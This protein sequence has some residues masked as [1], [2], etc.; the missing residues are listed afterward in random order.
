M[1]KELDDFF[2]YMPTHDYVYRPTRD[3]WPAASVNGSFLDDLPVFDRTGQPVLDASGKQVTIK[4][5]TWLDRHRAVHC[6]TWAP[7]LPEVIKD[8]IV[9]NGGWIDEPGADTFNL[10]RAP[11]IPKGDASQ[12]GPWIVHGKKLLGEHW[13]HVVSWLAHRVQRPFEKINHAIVLGGS[14]GI[15]KDCLLHP[16]VQAVG[17]WNVAEASPTRLLG[18]FN[19][20]YLQ[21]VILRVSEARDLGEINRFAFY[22][23]T[24]TLTAAPP[25]VLV[26]NEKF[27]P[28]RTIFNVVGV[29][30]TSNHRHSALFLPADDRRHYVVWCNVT[31]A[32]FEAGYFDKLF[33]WYRD[34]GD[35]H[36][37]AYLQAFDLGAFKAKEPPPK[38]D[39]FYAMVQ[40]NDSPEDLE[41]ADAIEALGNPGALTIGEV[42]SVPGIGTDLAELL[43]DRKARRTVPHSLERLGYTRCNNPDAKAGSQQHRWKIGEKNAY[44]YAKQ[45]LSPVDRVKAARACKARIEADIA[46]AEG[47]RPRV[48]S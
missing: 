39:A 19:A 33:A 32:D 31:S 37:A 46:K 23:A 43:S 29:F 25:D 7:G 1:T 27:T 48:V 18:Q 3:H 34:G 35:A 17:H 47:W 8:G 44:V 38:T 6:M 41:L 14:P 21:A 4:P 42:R 22:E 26:V 16:V 11:P 30:Y 28:E 2:A 45:D 36:V 10:Y 5:T 12:A 15:G 24:K 40:A 13:L 20:Q 9:S